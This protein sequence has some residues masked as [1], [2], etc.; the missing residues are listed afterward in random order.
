MEEL[1][2]AAPS[3]AS[4][5]TV[6]EQERQRQE[7]FRELAAWFAS[8]AAGGANGAYRHVSEAFGLGEP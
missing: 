4:I 5:R 8:D 6:L 7:A 2:A 1:A 3:G